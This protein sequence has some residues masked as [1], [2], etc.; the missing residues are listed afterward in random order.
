[1]NLKLNNHWG[2]QRHRG[3]YIETEKFFFS[4]FANSVVKKKLGICFLKFEF[5][6][7]RAIFQ[8]VLHR[9]FVSGY[10]RSCEMKFA[11]KD[12]G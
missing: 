10:D 2:T 4:P 8:T 5:D 6:V 3:K 12:H 11:R 7:E 9:L 1:M